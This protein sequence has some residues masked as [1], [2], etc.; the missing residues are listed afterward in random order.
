M[1]FTAAVSKIEECMPDEET[2]VDP[3]GFAD[4]RGFCLVMT[5]ACACLCTIM[6][7][8][9]AASAVCL[10]L[11]ADIIGILLFNLACSAFMGLVILAII[12]CAPKKQIEVFEFY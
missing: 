4:D 11:G 12:I 8:A 1:M 6:V 10:F 5:G 2:P 9:P 3:E 7:C